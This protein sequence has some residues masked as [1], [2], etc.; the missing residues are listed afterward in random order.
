MATLEER[1]KLLLECKTNP[2]LRG[3]VFNRCQ[4]DILFWYD[5]FTY[6]FNPR[7]QPAHL[8]FNLYDFQRKTV[9]VLQDCIQRGE[10]ILIEKSRD[11]GLSWLVML[12]FQWFWLFMDGA[13]FLCG[14]RKE[15][16]VDKRGD[17]STLFQ[18]FR[19]NLDMQPVWLCPPIGKAHD[20]HMKIINPR[21]GNV[22]SGE[23]ATADFGRSQRYRAVLMDEVAR[24]PY[25]EYAY[26]SVSQSTNCIVLL[27]TPFGKANI[28]YKLRS[29]PD[30]EWIDLEKVRV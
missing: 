18:K 2:R 12:T 22:L 9:L 29:H 23:A 30:V 16:D 28:A 7:T 27:W 5:W 19:Y 3:A 8:P 25:G 1:H 15:D 10:P 13:D 21:N 24:H 4:E 11:M 17:R 14:S 26:A 6:T 20:A